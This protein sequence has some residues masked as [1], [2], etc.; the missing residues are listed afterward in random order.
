MRAWEN[1]PDCV[2]VDEP[3]Y[4]HYLAETGIDHP[5]RAEVIAA[6]QTDWRVVAQQLCAPQPESVNVFY[7]KHMA[8]HL[9]PEVG[10]LWLTQLTNMLLIRDPREVVASYVKS[11]ES[12]T[13]DDIGLRQQVELYDDLSV[14]GRTP[15]VIDAADFLR[16]PEGHLR[17]LCDLVD[18]DFDDAMLHWPAGPRDGDGVWAPY[19]YEAVWKSTGFASYRSREITLTGAA[20]EV[21]QGCLPAYEGLRSVRW[22]I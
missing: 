3:L 12:V 16:D 22:T 7:Q 2:V 17:G 21:A 11:R 4:A 18:L 15:L 20:R 1:R 5:G 10:R 6:G 13:V 8:H 9:L 19:W 14:A